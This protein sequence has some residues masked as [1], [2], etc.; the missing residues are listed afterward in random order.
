MKTKK[1]KTKLTSQQVLNN[2]WKMCKQNLSVRESVALLATITGALTVYTED[3]V[4][5]L[6]QAITIVNS[7]HVTGIIAEKTGAQ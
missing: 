7:S 2:I 5:T 4:R 3:P 1:R 6:S